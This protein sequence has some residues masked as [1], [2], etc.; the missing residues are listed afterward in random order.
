MRSAARIVGMVS[1][2]WLGVLL[3]NA[4]PARAASCGDANDNGSVTVTDGVLV[5]RAAAQLP[6]AC[7]Q[8]R[9]DMNVDGGVTVTDGVLALR[10]AA[11]VTTTTACSSTT[12]D[13]VFGGLQKTQRLGG[14]VSPAGRAR[15]AGTTTPCSGGGSIDDDGFTLTFV[16]CRE[17]DFVTNGTITLLGD[18]SEVSA[19]FS[20]TDLVVSTGETLE[21][22]GALT[23]TFGEQTEVNGV[24]FQSSNVVGDY[25][26]AFEA[27]FLDANFFAVSGRI[28]T[29]IGEGRDFFANLSSLV[30]TIYSP[31]LAQVQVVYADGDSDF[32]TFA[33]GLCEPCSSGCSN[34][35]LACLSCID[36]CTNSGDRCGIDFEPLVCDDGVFAPFGLCDPCGSDTDC[37]ASDGLSCFVCDQN[38]T[39][40]TPR[41]GSSL[42]FVECIDGVF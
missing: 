25:T 18:G 40:D 1:V 26:D 10:V 12:V 32:F 42:A 3:A 36:Q 41:C 28:T 17:G 15:A 5:L 39:G 9:C 6:A 22:F 30:T 11:G 2:V 14:L 7:P 19:T 24:L 33:E 16:D 38:C 29:Q 8:Q 20:T 4:S 31:T 27:V 21:T 23:F 35:S 37:N 13:T 34:A